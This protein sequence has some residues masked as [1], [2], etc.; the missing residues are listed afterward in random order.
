[1]A[2]VPYNPIPD[3]SPQVSAPDDYQHVR[4]TPESFGSLIAEGKNKQAQG[5]E[6]LGKGVEQV[7]AN[8]FKTAEFYGQVAA[9]D[10][11]NK[12]YE[13][14]NK[15]LYGDPNKS[16]SG[17]DGKP[18]ADTGYMGL[19]GDAALR[20]RADTEKQIDESIK[21]A[22]S[23]LT[24]P[25]QQLKFDQ[26]TRRFRLMVTEKIGAHADT[27]AN[28]WYG[29]VNGAAAKLALEH[30]AINADNP[31]EVAAGAADL[32]Q[33]RVKDAQLKGGGTE[34]IREA[35]AEG[36]R[37]ALATQ[38]DAIAVKDPLRAIS[39]VEKNKNVAGP[40]YDELMAKYRARADQQLGNTVATVA[41]D[42]A[43]TANG[44]EMPKTVEPASV[45]NAIL[46]QESGNRSGIGSSIDGAQGPGQ[47]M[48][49]TF[50]QY[51]KPGES[52]SNPNDNRAVS[53]RIID[54]YMKRYNGDAA[55]V[56][57]AYF[58]GPG[59]VAPQGSPTPWIRDNHD[60][61]GKSV[62]GYVGDVAARL[63]GNAGGPGQIKSN[64]FKAIMENPDLAD[65]P[66]ARAHAFQLASQEAQRMEIAENQSSKAAKDANDKAAGDYVTQMFDMMHSPTQDYVALAGKINHD[67]TLHWKTKE[68]LMDRVKRM[69]G[70]EQSL[71]FGPSYL[72]AREGLF[73][74]PDAP[75]HIN[76][77]SSLVQDPGITTAGLADLRTRLTLVKGNV[78]RSATEKIVNSYLADAKRRLS[79]EAIDGPIKIM[80]PKGEHLFH[81]Q[82]TPMFI[83]RVSELQADAEKTGDH[84]K[85]DKFLEPQNVDKMISQARNPQ[86]MALERMNATTGGE[87]TAETPTPPPPRDLKVNPDAWNGIVGKPWANAQGQI[88]TK[89][90]VANAIN[91]LMRDPTPQRIEMFNKAL[92]RDDGAEIVKTLT[93]GQQSAP[94]AASNEP[95]LAAADQEMKLTPQEKSLYERHLKNLR[96]EGGVDNPD[97]SRSTLFQSV[98]PHDGKFY[99][100]PT[101]WNGKIETEK[102]TDPKTGKV[103]D[104]P[105]KTALANVEREGWDKFPSYATPE[106]ADQRYEK[107]HQFMERDTGEYL[108]SKK[109]TSEP[110]PAFSEPERARRNAETPEIKAARERARADISRRA[111]EHQTLLQ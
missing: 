64:A 81:N 97:G 79:F 59:N 106:E 3:V 104:V 38:T 51:A 35:I 70:E 68:Q 42:L 29:Q 26:D 66:V 23:N 87:G 11:T 21:A 49:A 74:A 14:I 76:D 108:K 5:E 55:R 57:V 109:K 77:F 93:G 82:F 16:T 107:M 40:Q 54:D 98:Q 80:D 32:I 52:I 9:D 13:T 46:N 100:I 75:G 7:G 22:R 12:T 6:Q 111:A 37:M 92:G 17:P 96:S 25:E 101:V 94:P 102:W 2:N 56:A 65:N 4:A 110:A 88:L 48:P 45:K 89:P 71:A 15:T 10:Q 43:R 63:G 73:S 36:K 8:I 85:L 90:A 47:I 24:S 30:I 44:I 72:K 19:K 91:I 99:N 78:D 50:N 60:G 20:S 34:L 86:Q 84:S 58:S 39:M 28:A 105:N 69:S 33:A 18:V 103:F 41:I 95:N 1:M 61:N 83:K 27:Q 67:T 53:G 62:S 31:Q